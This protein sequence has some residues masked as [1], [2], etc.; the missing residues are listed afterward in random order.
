MDTNANTKGTPKGTSK[1]TSE[2]REGDVVMCHMMR[3]LIDRPIT[4]WQVR[5]HTVYGTAAL[6]LNRDDVPNQVVPVS[7]TKDRGEVEGEHR[8]YIQG[9][10][11]AHWY[12]LDTETT[13]EGQAV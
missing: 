4:S 7:W 6:V 13:T 9:N 10:D 12:V 3:L 5:E 1:T 2:L 11:L 8:W